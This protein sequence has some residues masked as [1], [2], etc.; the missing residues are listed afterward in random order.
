MLDAMSELDMQATA[1]LRHYLASA[2]EALRWK[3]DGLGE[4]DLRRPLVPT[5]TNL[6]GIAKH[7]ALVSGEYFGEVFGRPSELGPVLDE[8]PNADMWAT[9]DEPAPYVLGLLA[10]AAAEADACLAELPLDAPGF[11]PWWGPETGKVTLFTVTVHVLAEL[12]RHTGQAD[13]VREL[14]DGAA[15]LNARS[16]NLPGDEDGADAQWWAAYR[17][18]LEALAETFRN[19]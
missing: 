12:N 2:F 4:H 15:G 3:L 13:I 1:T 11:V 17:A 9:A 6:L 7:V 10:T 16:S 14:V 8:E 5:G 19:P 18:R